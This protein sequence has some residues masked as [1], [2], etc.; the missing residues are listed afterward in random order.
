MTFNM[1]Q[2]NNKFSSKIINS[3]TQ[4]HT[5][6]KRVLFRQARKNYTPHQEHDILKCPAC[7]AVYYKK[8]WHMKAPEGVSTENAKSELCMADAM[9]QRNEYEGKITLVN[10]PQQYHEDI[11]NLVKKFSAVSM[12]SNP[13]HR[14]LSIEDH[15]DTIEILTSENQLAQKIAGKI[16]DS[17]K[18]AFEHR[19][20]VGSSLI[21]G[22]DVELYWIKMN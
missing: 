11:I 19:R 9:K 16:E 6:L 3:I 20:T 13:M 1:N 17:H 7:G 18:Q 14:V 5:H 8:G 10:V 12:E 4:A 2:Q 21:N 15:E 22:M